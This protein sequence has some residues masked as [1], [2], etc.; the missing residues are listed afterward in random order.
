MPKFPSPPSRHCQ[1]LGSSGDPPTLWSSLHFEAQRFDSS[2]WS[3]PWILFVVTYYVLHVYITSKHQYINMSAFLLFISVSFFRDCVLVIVYTL[4]SSC[5]Y[6]LMVLCD[7]VGISINGNLNCC[8]LF[9]CWA[10]HSVIWVFFFSVPLPPIDTVIYLLLLTQIFGGFLVG[11]H[12]IISNHGMF[13]TDHLFHCSF[14]W[15]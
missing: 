10:D 3:K 6:C 1:Q 15:R 14:L 11:R 7:N 8:S 4:S 2:F 12:H 13:L 9:F 5:A